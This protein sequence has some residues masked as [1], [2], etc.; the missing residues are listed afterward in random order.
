MQ[1]TWLS[2][3]RFTYY[4]FY[5]KKRFFDAI[6]WIIPPALPIFFAISKTVSLIRLNLNGILGSNPEKIQSA[7]IIDTVCFDKTG[8]LTNLGLKVYGHWAIGD[9]TFVWQ[10]MASC[11]HLTLIDKELMGDPLEI[12]MAKYSKW[13]ID[14]VEDHGVSFR[15]TDGHTNLD[16]IKI[17]EFSSSA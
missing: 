4:Y 11:H 1:L 6:T 13:S 16:I 12:E 7:G 17:F 9:E 8:T 2:Q 14:F 10:I 5:Q 3:G 15:V